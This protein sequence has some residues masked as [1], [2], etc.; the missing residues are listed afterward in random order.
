VDSS[1]LVALTFE[2]P[3]GVLLEP[4]LEFVDRDQSP[5]AS[6]HHTQLVHDVRLQEV[7]TDAKGLGRLALGKRQ[8]TER[9]RISSLTL[10]FDRLSQDAH[11]A[12]SYDGQNRPPPKVECQSPR[13]SLGKVG[14]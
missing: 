2:C 4:T 6:S 13:E 14:T 11:T 5:T 9:S 8:S 7:D 12:E 3:H 10:V 1:P